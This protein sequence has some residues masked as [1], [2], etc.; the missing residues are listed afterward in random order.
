MTAGCPILASVN[1]SSEVARIIMDSGAGLVLIPE[2]P[3]SLVAAVTNLE[4][5]PA[6]LREMGEA[7]REHWDEDRTLPRMESELLRA[8][9]LTRPRRP[10]AIAREE[11]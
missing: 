10:A 11:A 1:S 5:D 8:A 9:T 6:K 3:A 2:D 4:R 7:G